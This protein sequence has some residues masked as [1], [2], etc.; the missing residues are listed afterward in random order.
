M[1]GYAYVPPTDVVLHVST[2][3]VFLY[4]VLYCILYKC[5]YQSLASI[6]G[7]WGNMRGFELPYR[8]F[9][10]LWGRIFSGLIPSNPYFPHQRKWG[11]EPWG[12]KVSLENKNAKNALVLAICYSKVH[13]SNSKIM[14]HSK[15][16]NLHVRNNIS[17]RITIATQV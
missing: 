3:K 4:L 2:I 13:T 10:L 17:V 11:W 6:W 9:P 15:D 8:W 5:T 12:Q 1:V 7:M 16:I 14:S